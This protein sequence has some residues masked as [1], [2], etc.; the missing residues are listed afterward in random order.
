M[1]RGSGIQLGYSSYLERVVLSHLIIILCAAVSGYGQAPYGWIPGIVRDKPTSLPLAGC[2]VRLLDFDGRT[3][4]IRTTDA[5]GEFLILGVHAGSYSLAVAKGGYGTYRVKPMII[6]SAAPSPVTIDME[7]GK[8]T[9]PMASVRDRRIG[10]RDPWASDEGGR[11]DRD[12]MDNLPGARNVW[13]LLQNQEISCVTEHIDE[14]GLLTGAFQLVG[15]HGGTQNSYR[16]DGVNVTNPFVPGKPL[17]YPDYSAI[18]EFSVSGLQHSAGIAASG[19]EF[20]IAGRRG[21]NRLHGEAEAFYMGNPLQSTNLDDRLRKFGFDTTPHFGQFPEGDV[22]LGGP[23][24]RTRN[25]TFF[26]SFELQHLS[27]VIPG[28]AAKPVTG[29]YTGLIRVD[30]PVGPRD[31]LALLSSGQR[32]TDSNQGASPGIDPGSTLRR[33]DRFETVHG[34]WTHRRSDRS[35]LDMSIGFSRSAPAGTLQSGVKMPSTEHL[36][37][38]EL[39]GAAPIELTSSLS[40]LSARGMVQIYRPGTKGRQ[41]FVTFGFDLEESWTG[42]ERRVFQDVNLFLFPG[43]T[44]S[45]VAEFDSPSHTMQRLRELSLFVED[46][47]KFSNILFVRL[48]ASLDASSAGLPRQI[49][50]AGVY[51]PAREFAGAGGVVSWTTLSPRLGLIFPLRT[52][53][54][55]MR[56]TAGYSRY[57]DALP[58]VYAEYANPTA[59]GGRVYR[60]NDR[61]NDGVFQPGEEGTLLRVF[62]GLTSS[63]A[64]GL[65][66]PF[67]DEYVFGVENDLG[68]VIQVSARMV[69]RDSRRLIHSVNVGVPASSYTPVRVL[70]P[71]DDAVAGTSDDKVLTV[72][73]Q[74][75]ATLGLDRYLLTNPPGFNARYRGVEAIVGGRLPKRGFWAVEFTA[76]ESEGDGNP[77]NT[78]LEND[79]GTP[80]SLFDN[81]NASINSRGRLFFDRAYVAKVNVSHALP[82][83]FRAG[84]VISYFDGSPFGR[85]LIVPDLNQGPFF[86][87]ATPRGEP[88]GFRTQ[89]NLNFDQRIVRDFE[90]RKLRIKASLDIFNLLNSNKNLRE[91]DI[92]GP[93]F[94]VRQ[95]LDVQNPRVFRIG[96]QIAF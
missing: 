49:S 32:V 22:S 76:Y 25:W 30:A 60:W 36:F 85:K 82:L 84:S 59:L 2:E 5:D 83:G 54:G 91:S 15:V 3:L 45:E 75:Q 46:R 73:N 70:D 16:W 11:F 81:P 48:G 33:K 90:F 12:R 67:T 40:R 39:A 6:G 80:G 24:P 13:A 89:Y 71:G 87:M 34:H 50:G 43:N 79:P 1:R 38:G 92:T 9:T 41:H 56:F 65:K 55:A 26:S 69:E 37:T 20:E 35:F 68:G 51:A 8:S 29:V 28:F 53:I 44:P 21:G 23:L 63:V 18:Q 52:P 42:E 86:V 7:P 19:A 61:N 64:P 95:P 93:S 31:D 62:G 96:L 57:Y 66:R 77:G 14:G 17:F 74:D 94:V 27:K 72:Y 4:Q 88:G 58:A 10:P 78:A 47:F